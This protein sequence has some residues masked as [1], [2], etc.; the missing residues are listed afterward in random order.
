MKYVA[1][2]VL[3]V[4]LCGGPVSALRA[5]DAPSLAVNKAN[6]TVAITATEHVTHMAEIGVVHLGFVQYGP[7]KDAAYAAGSS[8][9]NAIMSALL[10]AGVKKETVQSESQ[11]VTENQVFTPNPINSPSPE[12]RRAK[13]FA[14]RQSWTVRVAADEAGRLLDIAVKAGANQSGQIDWELTDLNAAQ[15]EAAA[16]AIQRAQTQAK[17]MA[18]GLGVHLGDLLYASNQ[19]EGSPVRPLNNRMLKMEQAVAAPA[20]PLAINAREIETAAT[21]Y[22]VFALE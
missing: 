15:A 4:V 16:K 3:T 19:V 12:E 21:V 9:S 14:V 2:G 8:A 7:T 20:A 22:A 1:S 18:T 13:A 6:R 11:E 10:A 17:A 5:Q